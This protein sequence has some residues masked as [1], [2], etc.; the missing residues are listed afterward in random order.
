M[1]H[2]EMIEK[3]LINSVNYEGYS[4]ILH[5]SERLDVNQE[6]VLELIQK[7]IDESKLQG[8]I[9]NN[10]TRFFKSKVK[11][12]TALAL[13][14]HE[15]NIT[16]EGPNQKLGIFTIIL[17][18]LIISTGLILPQFILE[19]AENGANAVVVISGFVTLLSGLFYISR[20]TNVK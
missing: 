7:L 18:I 13:P 12:S 11:I 6:V 9:N 17:S 2:N 1:M 5:I 16:V 10:N 14:N 20:E 15:P 4:S 8:F 3:E 19:A